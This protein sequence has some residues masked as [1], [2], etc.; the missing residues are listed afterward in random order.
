MTFFIAKIKEQTTDGKAVSNPYIFEAESFKKAEMS[1]EEQ[2][3]YK[4]SSSESYK[5]ASL[6]D[7]KIVEI[8]LCN[9]EHLSE[10]QYYKCKIVFYPDGSK[11]ITEQFLVL[12]R[13]ITDAE[14]L[15]RDR[16]KNSAMYYEVHAVAL[17][18]IKE[19]FYATKELADA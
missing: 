8:I 12:E 17:T 7:S 9:E 13:S 4:H 5:I 18:N 10:A 15:L 14:Y 3:I 1:A 16:I 19:V 6:A 2:M 11:K